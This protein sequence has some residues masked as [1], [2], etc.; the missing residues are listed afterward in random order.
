MSAVNFVAWSLE[1]EL[2]FYVV[3]PMITSI[4]VLPSRN[5][6]RSLLV[7]L[8]AVF[9]WISYATSDSPR[10]SLSIIVS[11]QYFLTGFLLVDI[12]ISDWRAGVRKSHHWDLVSVVAWISI[13]T[14]H[15]KGKFGDLF[16]V[17][18]MFL[19][20]YSAF[21]GVWSNYFFSKPVIY[22]IG[23][24]CYTLYLYHYTLIF[25]VG[26]VVE[27]SGILIGFVPW[28]RIIVIGAIAIPVTVILCALLFIL[29]E[30][31]CMNKNW[32]LA[33]LE[34]LREMTRNLTATTPFS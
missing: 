31:P 7:L 5:L 25:I 21:R 34:R 14:L 27:R 8:I 16:I 26:R 20:Y 15:H 6:R 22:I 13:Y 30:K 3:A 2:Q 29:I 11:A 32:P 28:I 19:A 33:L 18:P 24:M 4:F 10:L 9:S 12:Y 17:I 23:G 1:V